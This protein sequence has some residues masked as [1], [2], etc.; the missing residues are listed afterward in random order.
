MR[1]IDSPATFFL[2][3]LG[4][5]R[6][7]AAAI[8][9]LTS[10]RRPRLFQYHRAHRGGHLLTIR[11]F[12]ALVAAAALA[13]LVVQGAAAQL[14]PVALNRAD[15]P[16]PALDAKAAVERATGLALQGDAAAAVKALADPPAADFKGK[17]ADFRACMLK[18]FGSADSQ[19]A[20][21]N[22]GDPW[23]DSLATDYLTYWR[24]SLTK[25]GERE[26]AE[27]ELRSRVSTLLAPSFSKDADFDAAEDAIQGE[28]RKRGFYVLLGRTPPLR[29]LMLWKKTTVEQ[30][31]VNLPEGLQSV[32]VSYLDD[33]LLRGWSY[34][35]TC[36][37]R[38]AGGWATEEGLF[39]V[40]PAYDSLDDETFSVNFLAHESQHFADKKNFP[41]LESWELEYRAKL[42]E[43]ALA[44]RSQAATLELIC[45]NRTE[46]KDS[47]HGYA[48]F[49]VVDDLTA[50]LRI[51]P[52]DLCENQQARGQTLRDAAR[53]VL[54]E[55]SS[56]RRSSAHK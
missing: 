2:E 4:D 36:N 37:S 46:S 6:P 1:R 38:S 55:D 34:Y 49:R 21:Q 25:P 42:V 23:I 56:K 20:I 43:L 50:R 22:F 39:A 8:S 14:A 18:R 54:M 27:R 53:T 26:Q 48:D 16:Q 47:P 41:N 35:A 12:A 5:L 32:R 17:D 19:P 24:Q 45:E 33:F 11:H 52:A 29:E 28:A 31:Q 9:H 3:R 13:C 40:V 7:R 15:P 44:D 30:R 10:G 51:K